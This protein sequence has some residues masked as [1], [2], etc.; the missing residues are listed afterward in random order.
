MVYKIQEAERHLDTI[1][2]GPAQT[3]T[4]SAEE[5]AATA[6]Y[7]ADAATFPAVASTPPA[8]TASAAASVPAPL[9]ISEDPWLQLRNKPRTGQLYSIASGATSPDLGC[10]R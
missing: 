10:G 9:T 8:A 5:L 3:T 6:P 4:T 1:I 7:P 2:S